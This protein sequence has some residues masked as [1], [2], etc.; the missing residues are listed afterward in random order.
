MGCRFSVIVPVYNRP[1]EV[2]EFLDSI[3]KQN[4]TDLEIIIV[5]D[6]S[7]NACKQIIQSYSG[8]TIKYFFKTNSGQGFSRNYGVENSSG[9]WLVFFDSD[10]VIPKGYFDNL[11]ELI[12]MQKADAYCGPD[13]A[14]PD[15][16]RLQKAISYSMT[17]TLTTGG[18]RGD[19]NAIE[20]V[21]HLRSYNMVV[22]K[23]VFDSLEGFGKTNMGEDMEFSYR[24]QAKGY[25]ALIAQNLFVYHK[26]RNT[27][28]SFFFQI[29]SFGRTRVQL[30]RDF[31]LAIKAFHYFPSIYILSF[32]ICSVGS[33]LGISILFIGLLFYLIH[34]TLVLIDSS[35][36]WKSL[37]VGFLSI[38]T[39]FIQLSAYG[40]GMIKEFLI[41]S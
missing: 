31:G 18:I 9:E 22:K 19:K 8:L 13:T 6:G 28:L 2:D 37:M 27:L 21:G 1:D 17:S 3:V 4:F 11:S 16:S 26:R 5:E 40:L 38:I 41:R 12:E 23:E 36:K 20:K 29:F 34:S 25:K 35:I 32:I 7:T 33:V 10:C 39:S 24:F 15:F 30:K 14:S